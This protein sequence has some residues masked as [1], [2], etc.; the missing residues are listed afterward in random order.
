[1]TSKDK[2]LLV[3]A[4]NALIHFQVEIYNSALLTA[5]PSFP[6]K[7]G[8]PVKPWNVIEEI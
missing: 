2:L 8:G 1:M 4:T 3:W 5:K 7:P 6:G